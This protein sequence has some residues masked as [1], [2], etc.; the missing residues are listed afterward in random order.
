M[1]LKLMPNPAKN[2]LKINISGFENDRESKLLIHD[3]A[4]RIVM[5]GQFNL[6]GKRVDLFLLK[7]GIYTLTVKQ[8]GKSITERLIVAK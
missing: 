7:N 5:A 1:S 3:I 6:Q 2:Y 4:G 8:D